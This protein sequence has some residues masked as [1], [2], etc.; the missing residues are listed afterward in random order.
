[1]VLDR[2]HKLKHLVL[3]SIYYRLLNTS[4][5]FPYNRWKYCRCDQFHACRLKPIWSTL[6]RE[7]N[8]CYVCRVGVTY[9]AERIEKLIKIANV[10]YN[11]HEIKKDIQLCINPECDKFWRYHYKKVRKQD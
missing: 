2:P 1:M 5:I 6:L 9:D 4:C 11:F 8:Y 7:R 3:K 10:T